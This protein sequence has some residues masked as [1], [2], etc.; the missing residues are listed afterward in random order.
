MEENKKQEIIEQ[1]TELEIVPENTNDAINN[2]NTIKIPFT[3]ISALGGAFSS[4]SSSFF[5]AL[6]MPEKYVTNEEILYRAI[7]KDGT[8][9]RLPF[10]CKEGASGFAPGIR[11]S[12]GLGVA[13]FQEVTQ[14][15]NVSNISAANANATTNAITN[16]ATSSSLT[17]MAIA[18]VQINHKLDEI[19]ETQNEIINILL[20]D[21]K[22]QQNGDLNY[23]SELLHNY[24]YNWDDLSYRNN[25][26]LKV[27]DI[28]RSAMQNMPFYKTRIT[29]LLA[30]TNFI[31]T[32]KTFNEK[33][34]QLNQMFEEYRTASY[35]YAY[36]S[37]V[38]AVILGNFN[39][40]YI[41]KLHTRITKTSHDYRTL[42]TKAYNLLRHD[43]NSTIGNFVLSGISGATKAAGIGLSKIPVLSKTQLD[44]NMID[45]GDSLKSLQKDKSKETMSRFVNNRNDHTQIFSDTL[46]TLD[47]LHNDETEI[48]FDRKNIY[49]VS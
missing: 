36:A 40:E 43:L 5:Q 34:S 35:L 15:A 38:G 33:M 32:H 20:D 4:V 44:E 22:S 39:S 1:F 29:N 47:H 7:T 31:N 49:L 21:K 6:H 42:Y 41:E 48:Y 46:K 37:F 14:T 2:H 26:Y 45:A 23:L 16:M 10:L 11:T 30:D 19:K 18:L 28:K 12:G 25:T 17:F 24:K 9:I 8:P 27:E 13:R 3:D